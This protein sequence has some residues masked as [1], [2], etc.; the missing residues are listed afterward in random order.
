MEMGICKNLTTIFS[1][2]PKKMFYVMVRTLWI[3]LKN[4]IEN[5]LE[6]KKKDPGI[7][8]RIFLFLGRKNP[9]AQIYAQSRHIRDPFLYVGSCWLI[10]LTSGGE[11][12]LEYGFGI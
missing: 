3:S 12:V 1:S 8:Q 2:C 4:K 5:T 9:A 6:Q 7:P 11:W 10:R